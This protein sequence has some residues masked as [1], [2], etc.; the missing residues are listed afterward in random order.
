[1]RLCKFVNC[2]LR[3]ILA[4]RWHNNFT[5]GDCVW[6][7][8]C[9][10]H[11]LIGARHLVKAGRGIASPFVE[12]EFIG[13]DYDLNKY[14]TKPARM[15]RFMLLL[16]LD[17]LSVISHLCPIL[18]WCSFLCLVVSWLTTRT[19]P[20]LNSKALSV[21][22]IADSGHLLTPFTDY[23][24]WG[25]HGCCWSYWQILSMKQFVNKFWVLALRSWEVELTTFCSIL[26]F[27][28]FS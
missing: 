2:Q 3:V 4:G 27:T 10:W 15:S 16:E 5:G 22:N 1:M 23:A 12:V 19:V 9:G 6:L 8:L 11:Q 26:V 24:G 7:V 13:C 17:F 28:I 14:K 18:R 21:G 25:R 20:S